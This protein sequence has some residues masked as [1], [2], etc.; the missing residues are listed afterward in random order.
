MLRIG[1]SQSSAAATVP[2]CVPQP[3][4]RNLVTAAAAAKVAAGASAGATGWRTCARSSRL[5]APRD[6]VGGVEHGAAVPLGVDEEDSPSSGC[7]GSSIDPMGQELAEHADDPS[8]ALR[9]VGVG[10]RTGRTPAGRPTRARDTR[11]AFWPPLRG[12][13]QSGQRDNQAM[14]STYAWAK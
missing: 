11:G 8:P 12:R 6:V 10:T 9:R 13:G 14:M 1:S 7:E 5:S 3:E 4:D 2:L